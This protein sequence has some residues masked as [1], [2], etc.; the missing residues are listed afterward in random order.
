MRRCDARHLTWVVGR[1]DWKRVGRLGEFHP[2]LIG[3]VGVLFASL[4][5]PSS[6]WLWPAHRWDLQL[7]KRKTRLGREF[8]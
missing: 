1:I 7:C 6:D 5:D 4:Y 8:C 3:F 2:D